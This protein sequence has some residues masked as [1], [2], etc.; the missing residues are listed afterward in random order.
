M[1]EGPLQFL[2]RSTPDLPV[3]TPRGLTGHF[4]RIC[5]PSMQAR[6]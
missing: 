2:E 6:E 1:P 3:D 4:L 5:H